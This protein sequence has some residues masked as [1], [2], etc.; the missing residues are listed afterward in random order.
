MLGAQL[1]LA[2]TAETVSPV[3]VLGTRTV[4]EVVTIKKRTG[5]KEQLEAQV[6]KVTPTGQI[7]EV[8]VTT[9]GNLYGAVMTPSQFIILPVTTTQPAESS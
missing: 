6:K 3:V 7:E 4:G 8:T 9:P 5:Q 1:A 2:T